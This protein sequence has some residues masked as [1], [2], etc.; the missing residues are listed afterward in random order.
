MSYHNTNTSGSTQSTQRS[1][2]QS[3]QNILT[4]IDNEPLFKTIQQALDYGQSVGL[5]GYHTHTFRGEVGYMA[6]INHSRADSSVTQKEVLKKIQSLFIPLNTLPYLASTRSFAIKG[7]EGASF[8]LQVV[9][10][11]NLFYNFKTKTFAAGFSS[12]NALKAKVS[13]GEYNGVINFPTNG[14]GLTYTMILMADP[15]TDTV[16]NKNVI[17]RNIS[18]VANVTVTFSGLTANGSSYAATGEDA[19]YT[20]SPALSHSTNVD[21]DT[22]VTNSKNDT[23]GFGLR[24][25]RQPRDT[26]WVF[27]KTQTVDGAISGSTTVVLDDVSDLAVGT[28]LKGV[29]AGSLSGSPKIQSINT[30]TKTLTLS[31]AQTFADGITLTFH[32]IGFKAIKKAIGLSMSFISSSATADALTKTVRVTSSSST[33]VDLLGTYGIAG[34]NNLTILGEGVDNA[35]ATTVAS[36]SSPSAT[37]GTMVVSRAQTLKAGTKLY[38]SGSTQKVRTSNRFKINKYPSSNRTI[39]F[40]LDNFITV[41]TQ[42]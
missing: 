38:L 13:G 41:G 35:T 2:R 24:L 14:D 15:S 28:I 36:I 31:S 25:I 34:G 9:T 30:N 19:V 3:Q 26:D 42:T 40:L 32:A 6:G 37:A 12:K 8:I 1:T 23:N 18:Q 33:N 22:F 11:N 17:H 16:L 39:H 7:D 21:I 20:A 5:Q 27:Q 4:Y 10:S 29:S